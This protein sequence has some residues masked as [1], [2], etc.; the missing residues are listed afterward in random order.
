MRRRLFL[1]IA[2]AG[3]LLVRFSATGWAAPEDDSPEA[4][5]RKAI[6]AVNRG[7][8]EDFAKEMHPQ[9]LEKFRA[10]MWTVVELAAAKGKG[11]EMLPLFRGT[12]NLKE[13]KRLTDRQFFTRLM[14]GLIA[15][16]PEIKQALTGTKPETIG[17][18]DEGEDAT[19]VLYRSR[20]DTPGGDLEKVNVISMK[21]DGARWAMQLSGDLDGMVLVMKQKVAGSLDMPDIAASRVEVQ[22]RLMEGEDKAHIVYRL[23]TPLGTSTIRK[24][25]VVTVAADESGWATAKDGTNDERAKLVKEK[26]GLTRLQ[27]PRPRLGGAESARERMER[28][29][30]SRSPLRRGLRGRP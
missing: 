8:V 2:C 24:M 10:A 11:N 16:N 5:V 20:L 15:N 7:K 1:G 23:L 28:L 27:D 22:G 9:S 29:R 30:E 3:V 18:L 21:K 14:R 12:K 13:L 25:G 6:S 26:L 4:V 19:H 17:H